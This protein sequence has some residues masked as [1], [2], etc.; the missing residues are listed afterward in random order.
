MLLWQSALSQ[1]FDAPRAR[2]LLEMV[3]VLKIGG[4]LFITH[5]KSVEE[6]N[7]FQKPQKGLSAD[8][9]ESWLCRS[10]WSDHREI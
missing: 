9:G 2:A 7:Q 6:L 10:R 1:V 8:Y 4:V 3:R 5:L